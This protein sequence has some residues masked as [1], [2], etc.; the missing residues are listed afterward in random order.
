LIQ[1]F[2]TRD[3]N[4]YN[5]KECKTIYAAV[6]GSVEDGLQVMTRVC[7][8]QWHLYAPPDIFFQISSSFCSDA[9][10]QEFS[11]FDLMLINSQALLYRLHTHTTQTLLR[12]RESDPYREFVPRA[13]YEYASGGMQ[14]PTAP[15]NL[16]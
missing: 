9:L 14:A 10:A 8:A 2:D 1:P 6:K 16:K 13:I 5:K 12:F 7:S 3:L 11:D 15:L 4:I